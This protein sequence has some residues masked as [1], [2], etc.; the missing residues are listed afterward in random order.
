[1]SDLVIVVDTREKRPLSFPPG[2][3]IVRAAL[4]HGDYAA[5][6]SRLVAAVERKGGSDFSACLLRE[7]RGAGLLAQCEKMRQHVLHPLLVAE[8]LPP[9]VFARLHPG[10]V[11]RAYEDAAAEWLD[12][13]FP[14]VYSSGPTESAQWVLRWLRTWNR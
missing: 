6:R 11:Y 13:G 9:V 12:R 7:E 5:D 8:L 3:S 4:K 14:T 1:M 2:I 10:C